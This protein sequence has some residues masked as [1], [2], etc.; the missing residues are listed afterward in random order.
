M[1]ALGEFDIENFGLDQKDTVVWIS[2]ILST[3]I[4]QIMF[5]NMLIAVMADTF[6]KVKEVE[7][8]SA[9]KETIGL[10]ADYAV[11]VPRYTEE[12]SL[13]NRFIFKV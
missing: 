13:K 10:M 5:L 4:A 11:A 1:L 6:D 9:L 7:K 3:F 2:F 8:Q 12:E